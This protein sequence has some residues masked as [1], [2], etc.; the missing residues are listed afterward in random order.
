M[1]ESYTDEAGIARV[2]LDRP[3]KHN[4]FDE[5]L[6][7]ALHETFA[8]F[9][10]AP[11]RAVI[12]SGAGKS[13]CAGAD[14]DWMRRAAGWTEAE[15]RADAQRLSD[16][17]AAIDACPTPVI[18]QVHGAVMGGGVGLVA[19]ADMAV[20][21]PD[22]RFALSEVRLGITPATIS[23]FVIRAIG[24]RAARRWFLTAERFGAADAVALDLVHEVSETPEHIVEQW[25]LALLA[26]APGAVAEA[27]RLV[28]DIAGQPITDELR[29]ET[30][31]RI[32]ARRATDEAQEGMAAFIARRP[33]AWAST[34]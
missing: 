24:P 14:A 19:C 15:N 28:R 27:K 18:A 3:D 25:L 1:L 7:A 33:P 22:T 10:T 4:A 8:G 13:F 5:R 6:V 12:L 20:A 26:N 11:P 30:A 16:M 34:P 29:S 23:P 2:T 32:A 21:H 31:A 17:L 9:A